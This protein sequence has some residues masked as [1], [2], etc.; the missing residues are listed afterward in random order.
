MA[1]LM[2]E[3]KADPH[4]MISDYDGRFEAL[5]WIEHFKIY[6]T[7][8]VIL[9]QRLN[10]L[11]LDSRFTLYQYINRKSCIYINIKDLA[12]LYD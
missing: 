11:Y 5:Q 4:E 1:R 8:F 6:K 3:Q 7:I 10:K 12:Y 2:K 9:S